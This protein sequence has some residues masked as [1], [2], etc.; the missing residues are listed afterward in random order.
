[1]RVKCSS[2]HD[3]NKPVLG[4]SRPISSGVVKVLLV[5]RYVIISHYLIPHGP[6]TGQGAEYLDPSV[7]ASATNRA[8]R[9]GRGPSS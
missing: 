3:Y 7:V 5:L 4:L 6:S 8:T 2:S 9:K 1:M